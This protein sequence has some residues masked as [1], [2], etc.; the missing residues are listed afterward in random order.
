[1]WNEKTETLKRS[2]KNHFFMQ[3]PF[4]GLIVLLL[5]NYFGLWGNVPHD[6]SLNE[7]NCTVG[8]QRTRVQQF[9]KPK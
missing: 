2:A 3:Q 1:V 8:L 9:I 6:R 5:S 4:V 7:L